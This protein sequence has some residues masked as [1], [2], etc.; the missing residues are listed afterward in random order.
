MKK[1]KEMDW[2]VLRDKTVET[3]EHLMDRYQFAADEDDYDSDWIAKARQDY[4]NHAIIDDQELWLPYLVDFDN[5]AKAA[6]HELFEHG[7]RVYEKMSAKYKGWTVD[8]YA[9]LVP[10]SRYPALHP[11]Q[12]RFHERLWQFALR[13]KALNK[14]FYLFIPRLHWSSDDTHHPEKLEDNDLYVP[15]DNW[16]EGLDW[17]LTKDLHLSHYFHHIWECSSFAYTDFIF[18][19]EFDKRIEVSITK[20]DTLK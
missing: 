11:V 18:V 15:N 9:Y 1:K 16:N 7:K 3:L 19:R 4:I 17:E 2:S 20:D 13:S 14:Y 12:D 8:V 10:S 6:M 5:A